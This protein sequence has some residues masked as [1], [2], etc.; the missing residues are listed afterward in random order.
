ML[1]AA[2]SA[3]AK[4]VAQLKRWAKMIKDIFSLLVLLLP[5]AAV[6]VF[7]RS[8]FDKNKTRY[9]GFSL[10]AM[11][12]CSYVGVKFFGL[13]AL[14]GRF[15]TKRL[16][17]EDGAEA[18]LFLCVFGLVFIAISPIEAKLRQKNAAKKSS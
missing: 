12:V 4:V 13:Y 11:G 1:R 3:P 7:A 15:D 14:A 18:S 9:I 16:A 10:V 17:G 6:V 8:R 2:C 5:A